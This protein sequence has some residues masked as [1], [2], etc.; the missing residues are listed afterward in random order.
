MLLQ[1]FVFAVV[2]CGIIPYR[3]EVHPSAK[4]ALVCDETRKRTENVEPSYNPSDD[5]PMPL[6]AE[7]R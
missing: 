4:Y 1:R 6:G 2:L 7:L 3:C 5:S